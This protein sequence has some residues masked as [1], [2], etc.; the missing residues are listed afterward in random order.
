MCVLVFRYTT[1]EWKEFLDDNDELI[2]DSEIPEAETE[3]YHTIK[4]YYYLYRL[5]LP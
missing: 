3:G 5:L 1:D 4:Y 2:E